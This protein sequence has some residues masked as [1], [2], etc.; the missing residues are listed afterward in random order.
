MMANRFA[1]MSEESDEFL[2]T[3]VSLLGRLKDWGDQESWQDFYDT[4]H[5]LIHSV[6]L[7][8]GLTQSEAQDVVQET[9]LTVA[10]KIADFRADPALGSFKGWLMVVTRRRIADQF[11]KRAKACPPNQSISQ[12][13]DESGTSTIN[14]IVEPASLELDTCWE[15]QWQKH[16]F[17]AA[18]ARVKARVSP[19]Q[20][21][22]FELYTLREWP[23]RRVAQTLGV[24]AASVYL[25]KHRIA[26]ALKR[27]V[28]RL[29]RAK[30]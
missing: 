23:L 30:P 10:K 1:A 15:E 22:M 8:A 12:G 13:D 19:L 5:R 25:A 27:E 4:Y 24:S 16:V 20:F 21:Q 7:K 11:E 18:V 17:E 28:A 2:P 29:E 3:R 6:A 9:V 14:R 26:A